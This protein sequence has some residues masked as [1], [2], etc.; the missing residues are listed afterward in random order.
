MTLGPWL[1]WVPALALVNLLIFITIRGRW[2]R[3]VLALAAAAVIGVIIGD[4]VAEAT[5]L[6]VLRIGDM[7][8]L[9]ASV[10]AQ[11]FMVAATLLSALGPIRIEEE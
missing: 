2:G 10:T 4:R 9:G 11:A 3:S 1:I 8:V 7:N 6:E 5:G